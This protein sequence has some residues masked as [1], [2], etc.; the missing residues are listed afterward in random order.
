LG[1]VLRRDVASG[2]FAQ[3]DEAGRLLSEQLRIEAGEVEI[4]KRPSRTIEAALKR[5]R[6]D[7]RAREEDDRPFK[8]RENHILLGAR[9]Q[10]AHH[11]PDL[12]AGERDGVELRQ[13][14]MGQS[15]RPSSDYTHQRGSKVVVGTVCALQEAA[16][17]SRVM[18][19]TLSGEEIP[20]NL[21]GDG[22]LAL[23]NIVT[24]R[25]NRNHE[26]LSFTACAGLSIVV[27]CFAQQCQGRLWGFAHSPST[28][29]N[30]PARMVKKLE[31]G[32]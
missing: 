12:R 10:P 15:L 4:R 21:A 19:I 29:S 31:T 8:Q 22:G 7:V 2:L 27:V 25:V 14:L 3:P 13:W 28:V 17:P 32:F 26:P 20:V 30:R 1:E 5:D 23:S 24:D 6:L 16:G 18:R 11:R 9:E